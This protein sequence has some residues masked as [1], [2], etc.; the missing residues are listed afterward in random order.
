MTELLNL[1]AMSILFTFIK[2]LC[3]YNVFSNQGIHCF[4]FVFLFYPILQI[5]IVKDISIVLQCPFWVT[6]IKDWQASKPI[7]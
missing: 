2:S 7:Q 6:S 4:V 5:R 3:A 1:P